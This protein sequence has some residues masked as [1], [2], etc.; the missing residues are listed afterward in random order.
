MA[1]PEEL[2]KI[3]NG[4]SMVPPPGV[5]PNFVDPP[6]LRLCFTI[7]VVLCLSIP[8]MV[9]FM[10]MYAKIFIIRKADWAD[11]ENFDPVDAGWPVK[12]DFVQIQCVLRG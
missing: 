8:T 6:N 10:R 1:S 2:Q 4:P 9:L 3:L 12:A 11:C 7:S 5:I